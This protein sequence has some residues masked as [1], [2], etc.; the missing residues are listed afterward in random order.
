MNKNYLQ[1]FIDGFFCG[2]LIHF[3]VKCKKQL[4]TSM[5]VIIFILIGAEH[6]IADVPY[7]MMNLTLTNLLKFLLVVM[8]NSLG[9]ILIENV[10]KKEGKK[11]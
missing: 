9:A 4:M 11:L 7:L 8:G 10:L 5:A 3:A 6:C 2:T 1:I